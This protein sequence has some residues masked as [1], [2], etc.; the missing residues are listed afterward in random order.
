MEN[1]GRQKVSIDCFLH[2][3]T[4]TKI[5]G[6][7]LGN[8]GCKFRI[9]P[10]RTHLWGHNDDFPLMNKIK[11]KHVASEYPATDYPGVLSI[12][13]NIPVL[14]IPGIPCDKWNS[15]FRF[16]GLTHPS[17]MVIRFQVCRENTKSNGGLFYLC[18]LAFK[19]LDQ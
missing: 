13:P 2:S 16:L 8:S 10:K 5:F 18:L 19:L 14:K 3:K 11:Y 4:Q 15:I 1:C 12:R 17:S 6:H 7:Y 9:K